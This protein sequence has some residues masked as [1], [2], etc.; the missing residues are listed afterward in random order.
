M[1]AFFD[2]EVN[3]QRTLTVMLVA[4]LGFSLSAPLRHPLESLDL[5]SESIR[6]EKVAIG[7]KVYDVRLMRE[8][9]KTR[10]VYDIRAEGRDCDSNDC[11]D[12]TVLD[13]GFDKSLAEIAAALQTKLGNSGRTASRTEEREKSA[14][15]ETSTADDAKIASDKRALDRLRDR[16]KQSKNIEKASCLVDRLVDF[17]KSKKKTD[18]SAALE[19]YNTE[20]RSLI[21][22][23]GS[24]DGGT[25]D[26]QRGAQLLKNIHSRLPS[27]FN[28]IREDAVATSV[29]M[30]K[31]A[32][33]ET[34][35]LATRAVEYENR[36]NSIKQQADL[37]NQQANT[38][39]SSNPTQAQM[40][41]QQALML[42]QQSM[43]LT[44][45][46]HQLRSKLTSTQGF[47]SQSMIPYLQLQQHQGL[48]SAVSAGIV[49]DSYASRLMS[50][51]LDGQ[52]GVM[53]G[54]TALPVT[55]T[56]TTSLLTLPGVDAVT[57]IDNSRGTVPG[58]ITFGTTR[59]FNPS[60]LSSQPPA[61]FGPVRSF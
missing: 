14:D 5:A 49:D 48:A 51:F 60:G 3:K 24:I 43:Q 40:L 27:E 59:A 6:T 55:G 19:F 1:K 53:T 47:V 23:M 39:Q 44:T 13:I 4:A 25:Y 22:E 28:N 37:L 56:G 20:I 16:C 31:K 26:Y 15:D 32:Q 57:R 9:E 36:A 17:L 61:A 41:R 46:A 8:G 12:T 7:G 18:A 52:L 33:E 58:G 35:A 29:D 42:Q 21:V 30:L 34:Q 45:G 2:T 11:M 50:S 10:A 38:L 54:I